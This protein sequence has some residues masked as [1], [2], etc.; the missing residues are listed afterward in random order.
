MRV[1]QRWRR[2]TIQNFKVTYNDEGDKNRK[3]TRKRGK[4]RKR[5]K[6]IAG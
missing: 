3:Y 6:E 5:E 2:G 4:N 1:S